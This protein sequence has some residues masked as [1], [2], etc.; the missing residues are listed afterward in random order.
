MP[1]LG[2]PATILEQATIHGA[3]CYAPAAGGSYIIVH[4]DATY[5]VFVNRCPHRHFPLDRAG[6]VLFTPDQAWLLC[7][8][9][10][11]KF[12]PYTGACVAGPCVGKSL[13]RL[14]TLP[15]A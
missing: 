3:T 1:H 8:N 15:S 9:H 12:D 13:Q 2:V 5:H 4:D 11:A 14:T 7:G 6:R 10:G